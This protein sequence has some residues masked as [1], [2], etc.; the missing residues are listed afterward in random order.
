MCDIQRIVSAKSATYAYV[1]RID[2][3]MSMISHN[4][5]VVRTVTLYCTRLARGFQFF[6]PSHH[7]VADMVAVG[8]TR[9]K[10]RSRTPCR[11]ANQKEVCYSN[12]VLQCFAE[13]IDPSYLGSK[14]G[15]THLQNHGTLR[16]R[17][18]V[19][20]APHVDKHVQEIDLRHIN[21]AADFIHIVKLMQKGPAGVVHPYYFQAILAA[22]GGRTARNLHLVR[23]HTLTVGSGLPS[24]LFAKAQVSMAT[25]E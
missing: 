1:V 9:C 18:D 8:L 16:T 10:D 3:S 22:K 17:L 4:S 2:I 15:I 12:A 19:T 20:S 25:L 7:E 24:I 6:T 5:G 11:L 13:L 14:L 23:V 21:P